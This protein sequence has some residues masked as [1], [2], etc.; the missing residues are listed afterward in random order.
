M[1]FNSE[2]KGLNVLPPTSNYFI[3]YIIFAL[4]VSVP[5]TLSHW[6]SRDFHQT[7]EVYTTQNS[8]SRKRS[9]YITDTTNW[10][11]N[12]YWVFPG[13]KADGRGADHPLPSSAKV[14]EVQ[15]THVLPLWAFVACSRVN[16]TFFTSTN[17]RPP[18]PFPRN[19]VKVRRALTV[20]DSIHTYALFGYPR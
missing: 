2:F 18:P 13:D 15:F 9:W 11:Y 5:V 16:F 20:E 19:Y 14:T 8:V 7:G 6:C 4:A 17:R 3:I 12:G 10:C 1:G